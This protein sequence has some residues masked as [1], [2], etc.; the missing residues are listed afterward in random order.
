[1]IFIVWLTA[2]AVTAQRTK[3]LN[4]FVSMYSLPVGKRIQ[5]TKLQSGTWSGWDYN[6]E[7]SLGIMVA[8]VTKSDIC[9]LGVYVSRVQKHKSDIKTMSWTSM[10]KC[11][12]PV[13]PVSFMSCQYLAGELAHSRYLVHIVKRTL[14]LTEKYS[15]NY[16]LHLLW[17]HGGAGSKLYY[18]TDLWVF[19]R[20]IMKRGRER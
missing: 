12:G 16:C 5:V 19:N 8:V 9:I 7:A 18:R 17:I 1:M 6:K 10:L 4:S 13:M 20:N 3:I 15:M 2:G 11:W 14:G